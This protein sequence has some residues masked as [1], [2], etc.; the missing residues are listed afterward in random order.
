MKNRT[1]PLFLLIAIMWIPSLSY[2]QGK[3]N[4]RGVVKDGAGGVLPGA[5]VAVKGTTLGVATDLNGVYV[6]QGIAAG[7]TEIEVNYLGF[8]PVLSRVVI[9]VNK[10]VVEDFTL[11]ESSISIGG[12]VVSAV[13]EGQQRALNQQKMAANMMQIISADQIGRF[14]DP[15]VADALK[16]LSGI[17]TDGTNVQLRGTP[18]NFTNINVNGE[19]VMSSQEE[20]KRNEALDVIPSDILSSLEVQKTLL[21]SNDGDAIAGAINMRTGTARSLDPKFSVDLG[22][23]YNDL[24][25]KLNYS[26][27]VGY[28][29]RYFKTGKNPNGVLGLSANYSFLRTNNGYDRLEA[30]AWEPYKLTN[31]TSG[32]VISEEAYIPTDFRYRYQERESSRHGASLAIDWAPTGNTKFTLSTL[33]NYRKNDDLRYRNRSRFRDN[34]NGYFLMDDGS[35]GSERMRNITQVSTQDEKINNI[36][37]NLDGES[38]IG[39]W[40]IDGGIFYTKSKRDYL[41]E[42]A[43]FQTPEWRAG[44]KVNGVTIPKGTIV[45]VMPSIETKY[46][47]S[48]YI[49]VPTGNMGTESPDAVSRYNLYTIENNN[50]ITNGDNFTARFNA[51]K[52]YFIKE[53][54]STLSFGAKG[55]FMDNKGYVPENTWTYSFNSSDA[56]NL[57]NLLY[58]EQ[59]TSGFLNNKLPFGIAPDMDKIHTYIANTA[60]ADDIVRNNYFS[61]MNIDGFYYDAQEDV[62]AGYVM[63]KIQF[64]QLMV[65]AG[66]RME[67]TS[68]RYKANIIEPFVNPEAPVQNGDETLFNDYTSTPVEEKLSYNKVL[69]NIQLKYDMTDKTVFRLAW[70]TG[71]S[72][73]NVTDLVPKQGV[74]QDLERV[75][76]GNPDL[77]PAYANNLDLLFEQYLSNVGVLSGGG[78]YKHIADFQYLSEGILDD[79]DS[80]YDGW[81]VIKNMNGDA[82]KVYGAE[83]TLNSSLTFLP[84]F[85]KNLV[86]TSN[87]TYV[88]SDATTDTNRGSTRLPGQAKHTANFALAY[89][90]KIFTLQASANYIGSYITALGSNSERDIWQD[91]R[92]QLDL[93][94]SFRIYKDLTL[95]MEVVNVLDSEYYNYFGNASRVYQLQYN[96]VT[97]RCGISYKF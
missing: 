37:I 76:L 58:T 3:G 47:A 17:T 1:I 52:N 11:E 92:W 95:W 68:V 93:N 4:L 25:E 40:K 62:I 50:A 56:N 55:K 45:G 30:E 82:A 64:D 26:A 90:T 28:S 57:G 44:K 74:S 70:T 41:S 33:Y 87:Y 94:G 88:H 7:E 75:T 10:T 78:F 23:G 51:S 36:N 59:L 12:V 43:G 67:H 85:L 48:E 71:Y 81:Q 29:Q 18:A 2:G 24:R 22:S 34:G 84:S 38:T 19:Q 31:K 32:E 60:N 72:R 15:N 83:V 46:L 6:L 66:V 16:R 49:Y 69:P 14:P 91:D 97:G 35:I 54:A 86:F 39:N 20:G 73:P 5:S 96:G 79:P 8:S 53:Y 89:S 77:K 61:N 63:N 65:L 13:I 42:M 80:R 27:K 21:P 9:E